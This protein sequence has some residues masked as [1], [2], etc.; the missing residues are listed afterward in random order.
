MSSKN[1]EIENK[2]VSNQDQYSVYSTTFVAICQSKIRTSQRLYH[3]DKDQIHKDKDLKLV[4]KE[5]LRT[6]TRINITGIDFRFQKTSEK[7]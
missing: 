1:I 6:R 3:K 7:L 4:L 5:S 2:T